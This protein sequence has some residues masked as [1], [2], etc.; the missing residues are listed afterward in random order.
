VTCTLWEPDY[1]E[2]FDTLAESGSDELDC[3]VQCDT[4]ARDAKNYIVPP[5][6]KCF[7]VT[8]FEGKY[9]KF[10]VSQ[11]VVYTVSVFPSRTPPNC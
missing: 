4:L 10:V 1:A 2:T 8:E 9:T 3:L 11:H 7:C 6:M 5:A